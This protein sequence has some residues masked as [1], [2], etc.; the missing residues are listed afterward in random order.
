MPDNKAAGHFYGIGVGPGPA[1]FLTVAAWETLQT[2][3]LICYPRATSQERSAALQT[4]EGLDVPNAEWREVA[5]E[6][7]PDRNVLRRHYAL[8]AANLRQDL[9]QGRRIAYLT[10]GDSL[11][12]S[13]YGYLISA[14]QENYPQLQHQT[15][16]GVTSFAAL[17][18]HFDWPLG[19]GKERVLL[20]PCPEN[21]KDLRADIQTHDV[22]VLLKIGNRLPRIL[23]LL[24]ELKIAEHC[25]FAQRLGFPNERVSQG[26]ADLPMTADTGYLS[27]MLIRRHPRELRHQ[28]NLQTE[29]HSQGERA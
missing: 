10:L 11:T 18:S 26:L 6:M 16:A 1:R 28:F 22:V 2:C 29:A 17:A 4:L 14:L 7:N 20:L 24:D 15:F 5:F 13:T 21:M 23:T 12:Y 8:M 19:E 3:D 9:E 27:T 25:V